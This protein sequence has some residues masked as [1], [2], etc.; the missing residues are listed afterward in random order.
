MSGPT[1]NG[2]CHCG[3]IKFQVTLS[4]GLNTA[5]RCDCTFCRMRG[6]VAV[7]APKDALN[8]V[9]GEDKLTLYQFGTRTARHYFCSICGIYTHHGRR[10]NPNEFGVNMACLEGH[11]PFDLDEVIVLDGQNHPT[12]VSGN[13]IAGRLRYQRTAP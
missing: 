8:V 7:S 5:R 9:E 3:A 6:A 1:L 12:D 13:R 11:S 2:Q 4:D 10:S